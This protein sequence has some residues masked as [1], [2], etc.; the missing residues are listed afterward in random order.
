MKKLLRKINFKVKYYLFFPSFSEKSVHDHL[1]AVF[2]GLFYWENIWLQNERKAKTILHSSSKENN[3]GRK[4]I[5]ERKEKEKRKDWKIMYNFER[6]SDLC[7][8]I[9]LYLLISKDSSLD[10]VNTLF[11]CNNF[12]QVLLGG[13]QIL[14]PVILDIILYTIYKLDYTH[15]VIC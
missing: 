4:I 11:L 10:K 5:S 3:R 1:P 8:P 7:P 6:R 15:T 13:D 12:S 9:S 14:N 2:L